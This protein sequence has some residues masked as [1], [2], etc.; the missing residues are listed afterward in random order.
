MHERRILVVD[1]DDS[2][3]ELLIDYLHA[4]SVNV[5]AARDGIEALHEITIHAYNIV[6][7]DVMMPKMSGIDLLDSLAAMMSD[8]SLKSL[9]RPPGV[10]IVSAVAD[11]ALEQRFPQLVKGVFRKPV[12]MNAFGERVEALLGA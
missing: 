9:E 8:P 6:I 11:A 10:L 2:I 1:D 7:L 4:H 3:R 5:D 12:D